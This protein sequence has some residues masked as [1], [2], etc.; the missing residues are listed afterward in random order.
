MIMYMCARHRR[1]A[2]RRLQSI[3]RLRCLQFD[4]AFLLCQLYQLSSGWSSGCAEIAWWNSDFNKAYGIS[5][6]KHGDFLNYIH[7]RVY[8]EGKRKSNLILAKQV[9][10][11]FFINRNISKTNSNAHYAPPLS[12]SSPFGSAFGGPPAPLGGGGR[13]A[14]L[15]LGALSSAMLFC[16]SSLR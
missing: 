8:R 6:I 1:C 3:C 12:T 5:R 7:G 15:P 2:N 14:P 10:N 16:S 4:T 9:G 13:P 11:L